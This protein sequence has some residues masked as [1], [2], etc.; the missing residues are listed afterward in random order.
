LIDDDYGIAFELSLF[1][2]NIKKKVC[3]VLEWFLPFKR[4][5]E[6]KKSPNML[7]LILN[8]IFKSLH[9]IYLF[10]GCE[11]GVNIVEEYDKQALYPM[12][13]KMLSL[14]TPNCKIWSWSCMSNNRC[15]LWYGYFWTNS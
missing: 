4:K 10:I 8:P 9:L 1:V 2:T 5:F 13:L 11:K 14:F 7:C 12:L 15:K 6:K 3:D